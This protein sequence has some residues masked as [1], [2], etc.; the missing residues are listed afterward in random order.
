MALPCNFTVRETGRKHCILFMIFERKKEA[1]SSKSS[2][3][4]ITPHPRRPGA[5]VWLQ[6]GNLQNDAVFSKIHE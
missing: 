6:K 1:W 2:Y 5:G 3:A 4:E